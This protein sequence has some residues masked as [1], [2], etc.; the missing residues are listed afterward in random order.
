MRWQW[1]LLVAILAAVLAG[2]CA[3]YDERREAVVEKARAYAIRQFP[4]L[5]EEQR[6][7]IAFGKPRILQR[8]IL[9]R[10][11]KEF[12][13]GIDIMHTC[14]VWALPETDG[15]ALVVVGSGERKFQEWRPLRALIRRH[16]GVEEEFPEEP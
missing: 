4:E 2:G 13:S 8:R 6:H 12:E 9:S 14:V 11:G 1:T 7:H 15:E 16:D 10:E 5:S 3:T